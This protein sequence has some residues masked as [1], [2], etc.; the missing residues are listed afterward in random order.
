MQPW[1][2]SGCIFWRYSAPTRLCEDSINWMWMLSGYWTSSRDQPQMEH[3]SGTVHVCIGTGIV[4][5][6][7]DLRHMWSFVCNLY[8]H[9]V[10]IL[11]PRHCV[12]TAFGDGVRSLSLPL[13]E[14]RSFWLPSFLLP[15]VVA[16]CVAAWLLTYVRMRRVSRV[17]PTTMFCSLPVRIFSNLKS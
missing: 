11:L 17:Y 5:E 9:R 2:I 16:S 14:Q 4:T 13:V 7:I 15:R 3:I 8:S 1:K 12:N 10:R 6:F